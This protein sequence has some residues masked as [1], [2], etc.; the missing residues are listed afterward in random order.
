MG[1]THTEWTDQGNTAEQNKMSGIEDVLKKGHF[2]NSKWHCHT[3]W[4][5]LLPVFWPWSDKKTKQHASWRHTKLTWELPPTFCPVLAPSLGF[6]E[7]ALKRKGRYSFVKIRDRTVQLNCSSREDL[8]G[9]FA[10][11]CYIFREN[12]YSATKHLIA[13]MA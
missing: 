4:G 12:L 3:T 13:T 11:R 1:R 8:S 2:R 9:T 7:L 6:Y 5:P 10:R